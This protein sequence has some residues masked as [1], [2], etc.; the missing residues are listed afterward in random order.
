MCVVRFAPERAA[1]SPH[2]LPHPVT[3]M[4]GALLL[5]VHVL[6][7]LGSDLPPFIHLHLL[8]ILFTPLRRFHLL[9]QCHTPSLHTAHSLLRPPALLFIPV[10][11]TRLLLVP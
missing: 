7:D 5:L 2:P 6:A 9:Y 3:P 4:G 10:L 11:Q 1:S 8:L